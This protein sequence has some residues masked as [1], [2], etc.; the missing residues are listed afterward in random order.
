MSLFQD[1]ASLLQNN[2]TMSEKNKYSPWVEKYR[3]MVLDE[4]VGNHSI[5]QNF[6]NIVE[7]G[8]VPHMMLVGRPGI[9]KTTMAN[10]LARQCLGDQFQE[11]FLELNAS[12]QR[13]ID[14]VRNIVT[15]FCQKKVTF[16][17]GEQ[18]QKIIFMDEFDSMTTSAQQALRRI[19]EN[20][21]K[22]T[23]FVLAC[24]DSSSVLEAIQSRCSIYRFS[25]VKIADIKK[26][27]VTICH[28]EKIKFEKDAIN[29][30]AI[31]SDGDV[32]SAINC[33]QRV[34]NT[35][36]NITLSNTSTIIDKPNHLIITK[37]VDLIIKK[38]FDEAKTIIDDLTQKGYYALDVTRLLFHMIKEYEM[39]DISRM[40]FISII[41]DIEANLLQNGDEYL[42]LLSLVAKMILI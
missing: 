11:A 26:L 27:L 3:P 30:I 1:K 9:G 36:F 12:E 19:I 10:C 16:D 7:K 21:S 32:R 23:R 33:L 14:T 38:K 5:V 20:F 42:Q 35:Y 41:G 13:G 37:L 31:S 2:L 18:K 28:K 34:H 8:N 40:K 22:T 17:D 15:L 6:K 39:D 4:V 29:E 25:K 24:N